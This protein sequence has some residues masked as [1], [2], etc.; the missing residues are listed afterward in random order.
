MPG[1]FR[2]L[3]LKADQVPHRPLDLRWQLTE[4]P[5]EVD[6]VGFVFEEHGVHGMG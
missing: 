6:V 5:D 3:S 2:A 1:D 4:S